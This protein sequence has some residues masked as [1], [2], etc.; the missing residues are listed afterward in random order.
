MHHLYLRRF[1]APGVGFH[2]LLAPTVHGYVAAGPFATPSS[3]FPNAPIVVA[4]PHVLA[5]QMPIFAALPPL[6]AI[7]DAFWPLLASSYWL[8]LLKPHVPVLL[9]NVWLLPQL[10][11]LLLLHLHHRLLQ[12]P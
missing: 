10:G 3:S 6:I 8:F 7:I 11:Q 1:Q 5:F 9:L 4:L 2:R 12:D